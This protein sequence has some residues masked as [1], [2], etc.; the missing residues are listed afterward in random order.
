MKFE[1][2]LKSEKA[3]LGMTLAELASALAVGQRTVEHWI[4]GDRVPLDVT[5]EGALARLSK[6]K[7]PHRK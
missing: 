7:T 3:R 4:N 2:S 1:E 6:I 5:R